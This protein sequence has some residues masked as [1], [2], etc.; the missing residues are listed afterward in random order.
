MVRRNGR[1]GWKVAAG[2]DK[3]LEIHDPFCFLVAGEN[4]NQ[5]PGSSGILHVKVLSILRPSWPAQPTLSSSTPFLSPKIEEQK[6]P[7]VNRK[8]R[9]ISTVGGPSGREKSSRLP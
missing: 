4:L 2:R 5:S 8:R 1:P 3:I 7:L 6:L 9:Y